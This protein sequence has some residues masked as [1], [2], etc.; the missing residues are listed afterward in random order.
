[1]GTATPTDKAVLRLLTL[2]AAA[3][4][5]AAVRAPNDETPGAWATAVLPSRDTLIHVVDNRPAVGEWGKEA[6]RI[7]GF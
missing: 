5:M 7:E 2:V 1:M 6:K 4:D 3:D